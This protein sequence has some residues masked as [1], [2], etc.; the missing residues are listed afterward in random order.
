M[1]GYAKA[2]IHADLHTGSVMAME[3]ST[4]VCICARRHLRQL[5]RRNRPRMFVPGVVATLH[6]SCATD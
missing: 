6:L 4:Q 5:Q 1:A 3:G 2:L